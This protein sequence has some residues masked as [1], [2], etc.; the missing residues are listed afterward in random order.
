MSKIMKLAADLSWTA[1]NPTGAPNK[2][3]AA[4]KAEA[5]RMEAELADMRKA[6]LGAQAVIAEM[7]TELAE[8]KRL[9]T[10]LC[11]DHEKLA[12]E[13]QLLRAELAHWKLLYKDAI[14]DTSS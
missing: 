13:A 7:R 4:L 12:M 6:V 14:G 10:Q 11:G 9:F 1:A 8:E 2:E 5:N 3:W